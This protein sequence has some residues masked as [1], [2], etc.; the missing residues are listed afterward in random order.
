MSAD[1]IITLI[2][3]DTFPGEISEYCRFLRDDDRI[4]CDNWPGI[5]FIRK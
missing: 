3:S 5:I 4:V 2:Y 1:E